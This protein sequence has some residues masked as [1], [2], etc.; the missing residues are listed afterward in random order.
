MQ[1]KRRGCGVERSLSAVQE[2]R[3]CAGTQFDP[4]VVEAFVTLVEE[5]VIEPRTEEVPVLQG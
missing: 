3:R 1:G 4:R 5:G 2:L